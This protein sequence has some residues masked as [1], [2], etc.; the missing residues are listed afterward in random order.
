MNNFIHSCLFI[1]YLK[2]T[3]KKKLTASWLRFHAR[4]SVAKF[5]L[6][7][8]QRRQE[9]WTC[10]ENNTKNLYAEQLIS[11]NEA[12]KYNQPELVNQAIKYVQIL[13]SIINSLPWRS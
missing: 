10:Q 5:S 2:K 9:D 12:S 8:L 1:F 7:I 4:I 6:N 13:S 11:A 3:K